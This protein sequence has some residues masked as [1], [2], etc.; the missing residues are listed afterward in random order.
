MKSDLLAGYAALAPAIPVVTIEDPA[1]AAPLARTLVEAGLP[2]IEVTLRTARAL[3]A[4]EAIARDVPEAVV[5]AGTI[6]APEQIGEAEAAGARFVVTPGT[7]PALAAALAESTLPALPGCA[8]ASEAMALAELRFQHLKFFPALA[9]GG[10]G[11]LRQVAG[12]LPQLRF[13]P[14]GGLDA[15]SAPAFLA[16]ANVMCV[17]G[18]WMA[19]AD[20]VAAGDWGR[21]GALA[22]AAAS[23]AR[24]G[25][26]S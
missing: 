11:W 20:A 3:H 7:P 17:G 22:R 18:A 13:C 23:L 8:T 1:L 4:V 2:V 15:A 16:C 25:E 10:T 24:P 14:T 12:P 19:P 21:I 9:S 5:G 26:G 6:V